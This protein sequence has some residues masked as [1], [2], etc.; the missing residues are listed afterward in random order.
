MAFRTRM[1][2]D[3]RA[4]HGLRASVFD[5]TGGFA[6]A[7]PRS[8]HSVVLHIGSPVNASC[9]CDGV[10]KHRRSTPGDIDILPDVAS[11]T[12]QEDG[13]TTQLDIQL[14]PALVRTA[15]DSMALDPDRVSFF[16]Q[17]QIRD[18]Q[19]ESIG[20]AL[21]AELEADYPH[22]RVFAE[23]L[24]VALAVNL[25]RRHTRVV[26]RD[27]RRGLSRQRLR[28]VLRYI[29]DNLAADLS[30]SELAAIAGV[31]PSH[32]IVLFKQST[33]MATHQFIIRRRVDHALRLAAGGKARLCDI[34]CESGF[35]DQSHMAR[36]MRRIAGVTPSAVL[37][38]YR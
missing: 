29:D 12:W 38:S 8:H 17:L 20:R 16:P 31:S 24:G 1:S 23:G 14:A 33:G 5:T 34:A 3:G 18:V 15:A 25:L 37:R 35:S 6:K 21:K 19:I 22:D 2:S 36:C 13:P 27:F 30:L 11:A 10:T 7:G 26:S 4:W 28:E 32:F 9:Q